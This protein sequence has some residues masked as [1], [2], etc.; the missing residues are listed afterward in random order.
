MPLINPTSI[1]L[2]AEKQHFYE[3]EAAA[4]NMPLRTYLRQRLEKEDIIL[5]ELIA[6]RK[7][8]KDDGSDE[9][10][11]SSTNVMLEILLLLRQIAQPKHVHLAH[12]E[13]KRLGLEAWKSRDVEGY[14]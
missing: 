11:T 5:E 1:R 13:L 7:F 2:S 6:L 10:Q 3:A 14:P 9:G 8:M 4:K 12:Q